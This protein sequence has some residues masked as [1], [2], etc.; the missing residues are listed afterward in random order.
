MAKLRD[1]RARKG[2]LAPRIAPSGP[3]LLTAASVLCLASAVA[4]VVRPQPPRETPARPL[5]GAWLADWYPYDGFAP[6]KGEQLD[7]PQAMEAEERVLAAP[8]GDPPV[9]DCDGAR[10]IVAQARSGLAMAAEPVDKER[11]ASATSDWLDPHGLWS[12]APDAPIGAALLEN[13]VAQDLEARP[14]SGP[15]TAAL[16]IGSALHGW[17]GDLRTEVLS[18][19][20]AARRAGVVRKHRF[21]LVTSTPFE[22]GTVT[23]RGHDLA[24]TL[25]QRMG[26]LEAAFGPSVETYTAVA[27]DRLAPEK[28]AE[29]WAE[30]VLAAAVRAYIPQID[31]HGAWA[32]LDEEASIYDVDLEVDPPP[33]MWT[34]MTRTALGVRIDRGA[35]APL[36][37]GDVVLRV[38]ASIVGG[39]SVEQ[40]NQLSFLPTAEPVRATVLRSDHPEPIDLEVEA[41]AELLSQPPTGIAAVGLA[42]SQVDY[43]GGYALVIRIPDVPDDLGERVMAALAHVERE[44]LGVLLDLR[45]N[46]GGS[47]DGA[48]G[49]LG[50]FLPGAP[51][52]P[53]RRR[54]GE[55][56]VDRA[57]RPPEG[58]VWSG[59]VATL[60]DGESASAAEMIAGA[61]AAYDRGP[62]VGSRTYGKGCAQ[63][64]LDDDAGVGVLRLTT[65]VFSLPDGT[66][67]QRLGVTPGIALG[68]PAGVDREAALPHAPTTWAGPDV[69]ATD[70]VRQVAW[71]DHAGRIGP[72]DD[73]VIYRALRAL[74]ATRVASRN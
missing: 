15:C 17:V 1:R 62:A 54:D 55:I 47:T 66:P 48:L 16:A 49:A 26:A 7:L 53:M 68:L 32:P 70:L 37:D 28:T 33:R 3:N 39:M 29:Q 72:A 73:P 6:P 51:L 50:V 43:G 18:A 11:F 67:V 5:W 58:A 8:V 57:P 12:V 2:C 61:L 22:D 10:K 14:G 63:E 45:G 59:P 27:T 21:D 31:P 69:R 34:E 36:R 23:R 19:R 42:T 9:I 24:R 60:V 38:G 13:D 64:Y 65:L 25:G 20:A 41:H 56:S 74:G 30:I 44:P 46:G 40:A 4:V 35:R 52:F 71:P